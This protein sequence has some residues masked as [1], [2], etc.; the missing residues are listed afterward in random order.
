ML[1][2]CQHQG[3][4]QFRTVAGRD[5]PQEPPKPRIL[6]RGR[7]LEIHF[8]YLAMSHLCMIICAYRLANLSFP[9]NPRTYIYL[10]AL[11]RP[12]AAAAKS[13]FSTLCLSFGLE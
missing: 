10:P 7:R 2:L 1:I 13:N 9:Y 12:V 4:W 3:Q 6:K 11:A 8:F 5:E